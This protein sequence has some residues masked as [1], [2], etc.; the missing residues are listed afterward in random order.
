MLNFVRTGSVAAHPSRNQLFWPSATLSSFCIA[1]LFFL[2]PYPS[3]MLAGGRAAFILV[4]HPERLV[5][6]NRYQ[7]E[8]TDAERG[9]LKAFVPMRIVK[10]EGLLSDGFTRCMQVEIDGAIYY[11]LIDKKGRLAGSGPLGSEKRVRNAVAIGDTVEILKEGNVEFSAIGVRRAF[12]QKGEK[13]LRIFSD[14]DSVYCARAA[15]ELTYGWTSLRGRGDGRNWKVISTSAVPLSSIPPA[16][17]EKV[18]SRIAQTNLLLAK[19]FEHF[20]NE[21]HQQK[22]IPRWEVESSKRTI[23]CTLEGAPAGES[24]ERSTPYLVK[25]LE[26]IVLG[27]NLGVSHSPGRIEIRLQ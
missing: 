22:E 18:R 10:A 17:V 25:D 16:I 19:L 20:N 24:F 3:E 21:T 1:F 15:G 14:R 6:Y 5:V 13:V 27:S 2:L 12:L 7:Q 11:L 8:A 4:P 23:S 26:N 9:A